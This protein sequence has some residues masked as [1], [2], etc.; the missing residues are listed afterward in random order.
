MGL[1]SFIIAYLIAI[2]LGIHS[3]VRKGSRFDVGATV[4]LLVLLYVLKRIFVRPGYNQRL[5]DLERR[6]VFVES[7]LETGEPV[8]V[9][10][11]RHHPT[12]AWFDD[13]L[14]DLFAK[15]KSQLPGRS[16]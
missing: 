1:F 15:V 5:L 11:T 7:Y 10:Y 9:N 16:P 4:L 14:A 6:D 8:G 3:A 12:L 13:R 2:P